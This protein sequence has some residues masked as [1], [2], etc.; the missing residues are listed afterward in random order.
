MAIGYFL[1]HKDKTTCGGMIVS[2]SK[3]DTY[4]GRQ[5]IKEGDP[6]TCGKHSGLFKVIGG[7][8]DIYKASGAPKQF[9]GS[10]ESFSSCPCRAKFIPSVFVDTYHC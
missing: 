2:G 6:V 7:I 8:G 9:A 3:D 5:R 1:Y 10:I 4:K